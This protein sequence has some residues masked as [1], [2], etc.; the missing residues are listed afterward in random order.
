M[1]FFKVAILSFVGFSTPVLVSLFTISTFFS[2][3]EEEVL[4]LD[5]IPQQVKKKPEAKPT[6]KAIQVR[7][8]VAYAKI[9]SRPELDAVSGTNFVVS[10]LVRFDELPPVGFRNNILAKY[11]AAKHPYA[12]WAVGFHRLKTSFRPEVYLKDESGAGGWF[13]F[14]N[15]NLEPKKWYAITVLIKPEEHMNLYV[16]DVESLVDSK[17]SVFSSNK[18][19]ITNSEVVFAGG[20]DISEVKEVSTNANL[21][22]GATRTNKAGFQGEIALLLVARS[23]DLGQTIGELK[24]KLD[25]GSPHIAK[26]LKDDQVSLWIS[27]SGVDESRFSSKVEFA[28]RASWQ[29]AK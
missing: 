7:K 9:S 20:H 1:S 17:G 2:D 24:K 22:L 29:A 21:I 19:L 25:G 27:K 26:K 15:T 16:Q 8:G 23:N 11:D 5:S 3:R 28:G 4:P 10:F 12:G 14:S 6:A 13:S 18:S